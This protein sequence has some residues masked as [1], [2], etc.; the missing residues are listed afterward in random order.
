VN[1]ASAYGGADCVEGSN[2]AERKSQRLT[3]DKEE[4][5]LL[6]AYPSWP[7]SLTLLLT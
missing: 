7:K 3:S 6:G 4:H 2:G 1:A 5:R